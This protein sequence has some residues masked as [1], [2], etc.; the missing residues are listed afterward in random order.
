MLTT[1]NNSSVQFCV[2]SI[3][4]IT[5]LCGCGQSNRKQI[6]PVTGVVT[7]DG[8]PFTQG[9][10]VIFSPSA[11]GKMSRG[12]VQSDGTFKLT[13][14]EENDGAIIGKQNVGVS[15]TIRLSG[16]IESE[17]PVTGS[18]IP[19]EYSAPETSGLTFEVKA[20]QANHFLI[21]LKSN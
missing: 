9:A 15:P 10:T 17:A 16:G 1:I 7:L 20:D 12:T 21:P 3:F 14:Y 6:A 11:A 4:S 19:K 18:A 5:L 13:T 2:V 8:K